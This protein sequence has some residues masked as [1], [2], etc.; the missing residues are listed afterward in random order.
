MSRSALSPVLVLGL[1]LALASFLAWAVLAGGYRAGLVIPAVIA[2][3]V[4]V[5]GLRLAWARVTHR[6][7]GTTSNAKWSAW[8][9]AMFV[10]GVLMGWLCGELVGFLLLPVL[11]V[12]IIPRARRQGLLPVT[13]PPF[14]LGLVLLPLLFLAVDLSGGFSWSL[15]LWFTPEIL[16]GAL[17]I[18]PFFRPG[19][20]QYAPS[21]R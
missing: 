8:G 13:L 20:H 17:L 15:V 10:L 1:F 9:L 5:V 21:S 7:Q 16:I 12:V 3:G 14:G 18:V 6:S 2:L 19:Q 4:I 11:C